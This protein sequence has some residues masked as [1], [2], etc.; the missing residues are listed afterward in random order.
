MPAK[1]KADSLQ[2][3]R[4]SVKSKPFVPKIATSPKLYHPDSLH[5]PT[6]AWHRSV[7][8]PGW[9]QVYNR[10]Y[11]KVPIIYTGFTLL[12]L[13][14]RF[15]QDLYTQDLAIAR[16]R[17]RGTQPAPGDKYYQL[18]QNYVGYPDQS[19]TDATRGYARYRDLAVL[20]FV[21][22]WG[23]QT[24]DAYVDAKFKHSYSMDSDFSVKL[25]PTLINSPV[26]AQTLGDVFIPGLKVTF[27]L[28]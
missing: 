17:A 24:I 4:D 22:G 23:I 13:M 19:I 20:I 16:Y 3:K 8:I 14:Y 12:V 11:W 7:I 25:R 9:G 2:E 18:Y 6:K 1:S 15:N 27:T 26:Y 10:Q 5:S 28:P 21:A